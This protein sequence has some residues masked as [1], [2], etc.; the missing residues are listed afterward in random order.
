MKKKTHLAESHDHCR[1][2]PLAREKKK[3]YL[4]ERLPHAGEVTEPIE[5]R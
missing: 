1:I 4:A 3:T 2:F 5:N